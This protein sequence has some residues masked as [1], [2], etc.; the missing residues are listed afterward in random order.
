MSVSV[1]PSALGDAAAKGIG[2]VR[3]DG[4][5]FGRLRID[6]RGHDA[7]TCHMGCALC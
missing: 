3:G 4:H 6:F 2:S 1:C 5:V 7:A